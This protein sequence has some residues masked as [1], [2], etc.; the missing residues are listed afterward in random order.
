M[1]LSEKKKAW[2]S[3]VEELAGENMPYWLIGRR[4]AGWM[5]RVVDH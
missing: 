1:R 3:P 4:V 2:L 5:Q